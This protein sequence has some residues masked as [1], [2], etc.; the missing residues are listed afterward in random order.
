MELP[1][2][3]FLSPKEKVVSENI[4]IRTLDLLKLLADS[5][6]QKEYA[7][8]VGDQIAITEMVC[9]WFDDLYDINSEIFR[10]AFAHFELIK[11]EKFN[12]YFDSIDEQIPDERIDCL[13][14]DPSWR[15][16]MKR[17]QE[18]HE[19]LTKDNNTQQSV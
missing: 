11:L 14:K 13:L 19:L 10:F 3:R 12:A 17:A 8:K 5:E 2:P 9:M 18:T 7:G 15:E 6:S 16:L 4:R 1:K